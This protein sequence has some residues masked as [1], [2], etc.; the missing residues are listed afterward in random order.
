MEVDEGALPIGGKVPVD[1]TNEFPSGS[2]ISRSDNEIR[3]FPGRPPWKAEMPG[4]PPLPVA[5][6]RKNA[7]ESRSLPRAEEMGRVISNFTSFQKPERCV[8]RTNTSRFAQ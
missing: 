8:K 2:Y 6:Q 1:G 3:G 7:C 4:S 5:A